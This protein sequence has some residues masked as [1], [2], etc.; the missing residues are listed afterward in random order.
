MSRQLRRMRWFDIRQVAGLDAEIFGADAWTEAFFWSVMAAPGHEF[1]VVED[2]QPGSELL[3]AE[4]G[5]AQPGS[6]DHEP[7]IIGFAGLAVSGPQSDILTIA[8]HPAVRGQGV[9]TALLDHLLA[10]AR[11]HGCEVIHL[12]VR[13]DNAVA[14]RLYESYGFTEL[15]RRRG[16]YHGADAVVMRAFLT[17]GTQA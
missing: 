4:R 6:E 14:L 11:H 13:S 10:R 16:Y 9:G 15:G 12:D 1:T 2:E 5:E 3:R 8:S 7:V 17:H